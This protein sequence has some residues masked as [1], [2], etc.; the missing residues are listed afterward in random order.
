MFK[1]WRLLDGQSLLLDTPDDGGGGGADDG[2]PDDGTGGD[3]D[4]HPDFEI[5]GGVGGA[6]EDGVEAG[7]P[8]GTPGGKPKAAAGG[9][10]GGRQQGRQD[11]TIP[12][13]RL[14]EVS[15]QRD[16]LQAEVTTTKSELEKLKRIV[17]NAL[18]IT[19]PN[20]GK[21][22]QLT[23]REKAIQGRIL[24]LFPELKTLM[25]LAPKVESLTGLA[26]QMPAFER[27]S[28]QYW[29][30]VAKTMLDG[31][32]DA[33]APMFL[34]EGK[35]ASDLTK[36]QRARFQVDFFNWIQAD[37]KRVE[38]YEAIDSTLIDEYRQELDAAWVQPLRRQSGVTALNRGRQVGRLPVGGNSSAPASTPKPKQKPLDE[39]TAADAAWA[40]FQERIAQG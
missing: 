40:N 30:R 23:D 21:P 8:P 10:P 18:G 3:P 13:Y 27:Q 12:K 20:E 11:E 39:D 9:Q 7:N 37:D 25:A 22:R 6:D 31:M 38:R 1:F 26:D 33:V 29:N 34:G 17:T 36:E 5:P 16:R 14:D 24:E 35:K 28:Q 19:D 2:N 15:Q 32:A 4:E